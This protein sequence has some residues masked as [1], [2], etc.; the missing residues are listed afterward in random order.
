MSIPAFSIGEW[1][2]CDSCGCTCDA[3]F[4]L[5]GSI[6]SDPELVLGSKLPEPV[7]VSEGEW[8]IEVTSGCPNCGRQLRAQAVFQGRTLHAF[9]P[10]SST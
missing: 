3:P 8:Q 4:H 6:A 7:G 10:I 9:I 1:L 5:L 2:V